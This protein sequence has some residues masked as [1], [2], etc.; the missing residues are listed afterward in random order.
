MVEK[1]QRDDLLPISSIVMLTSA[2]QLDEIERCGQLGI[3]NSLTKPIKASSLLDMANGVITNKPKQLAKMTYDHDGHPARSLHVLVV[4]DASVNQD[5][6]AGLLEL[7]EHTVELA[8]NG[9]A[10]VEAV[11]R[12]KFDAVLMDVEMPEMDG[13]AATTIIREMESETGTHT[14]IIA[15]TAH[16]LKGFR[17]KCVAAGMDDYISKPIQPN[18]LFDIL[19]KVVALHSTAEPESAPA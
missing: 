12:Q 11:K 8:D 6:A 16:A 15:M 14:P 17:E 13:L 18:E 3:V 5:V 2:G 4:D 9:R 1:L 10:A 7:R 19:D